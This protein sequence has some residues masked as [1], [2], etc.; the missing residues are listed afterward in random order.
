MLLVDT[1]NNTAVVEWDEDE[2]VSESSIAPSLAGYL[3][4]YR[5]QLL[6]GKCEFLGDAG[7]VER[8]AKQR[9]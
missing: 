1:L 5:N 9:K 6:S 4:N 3:E 8:I 2:G 7:V